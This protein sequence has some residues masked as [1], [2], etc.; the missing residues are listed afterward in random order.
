MQ[1]QQQQQEQ[2]RRFYRQELEDIANTTDALRA[3]HRPGEGSGDSDEE[4]FHS[5]DRD[6]DGD[7]DDSATAE[8][9][10]MHTHIPESNIGYQLLLKMGWKA[11]KGLGQNETGRTAPIT[12]ERKQDVSG[13]GKQAVDDWYAEASTAKR[14]TLEAEKQAEETEEEKAKREL[15]VEKK[16]ALETHLE[17]VKSSF[18]CALCDKQYERISE[19]EVHLSSYDH[20][21]K[22]RFKDMKETSRAGSTNIT[23]KIKEKERK[24]EERELAKLQEAAMKRTGNQPSTTNSSNASAL[25]GMELH[26]NASSEPSGFQPVSL[27]GF[28]PVQTSGF[29]SVTIES[30]SVPTDGPK[31]TAAVSNGFQPVKLGG[32]Q[33]VKKSGFQPVK[34]GGFQPVDGDEDEEVPQPSTSS[35]TSTN[36]NT[37]TSINTGTVQGASGF[38]PVKLGGFKPMKIGGFQLKRPGAK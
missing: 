29:N 13:L 17:I 34:L 11:G 25:P 1:Q 12:I 22:K 23:S 27:G 8:A 3:K 36:T 26:I 16:R 4:R 14:K 30:P 2:I 10:D 35:T 15:H 37:G 5:R 18:Y 19:Y 31:P 32:F 20:N 6:F 7:D 24:R 9:A 28:N 38:Q 21:H 33:P